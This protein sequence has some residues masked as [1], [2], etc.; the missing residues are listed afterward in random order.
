MP[1]GSGAAI[2]TLAHGALA[3]GCGP[4][5]CAVR[6]LNGADE[7]ILAEM[8][9]ALPV[10]ISSTLLA[11]TL[12][13]IGDATQ[14]T[15][16]TVRRLSVGDR[17]KLLLALHATTFGKA[18]ETAAHCP[19]CHELFEL[20]LDLTTLLKTSFDEIPQSER[21]VNARING[22]KVAVRIRVAN[23]IDQELTAREAQVNIDGAVRKL[24]CRCIVE[25]TDET[26]RAL[27]VEAVV[28]DLRV[29]I[30]DVWAELDPAAVTIETVVCP[31]CGQSVSVEVD[32]FSLIAGELR[33]TRAISED[34]HRLAAAYHWSEDQILRLPIKR[35]RRYL[36]L[37][38][39]GVAA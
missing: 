30:E 9:E 11:R 28:D 38:D 12:L 5:Q 35:R 21:V 13:S 3:G 34:V 2:V 14:V 16:E 18:V 19:T 29:A 25:M 32:A 36:A 37:I 23:G 15:Y 4:I 20:P 31:G 7:A 10:E 22:R 6:P 1:D 33:Y 24:L 27:D 39:S 17:E 8:G 26:G